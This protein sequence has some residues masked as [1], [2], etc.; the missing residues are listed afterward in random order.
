MEPRPGRRLLRH[1]NGDRQILRGF[2]AMSR[3]MR[4]TPA[5]PTASRPRAGSRRSS[6]R[7]SS[8]ARSMPPRSSCRPQISASSTCARRTPRPRAAGTPSTACRSRWCGGL[9]RALAFVALLVPALV[10]APWWQ[11]T[12]DNARIRVVLESPMCQLAQRDHHGR[13][14][15]VRFELLVGARESAFVERSCPRAPGRVS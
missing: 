11:L 13:R 8:R 7:P 9:E 12:G 10:T 6:R 4:S 15:F 14:P 3:K 5:R 2:R 1:V